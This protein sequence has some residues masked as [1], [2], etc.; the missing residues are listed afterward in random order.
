[1]DLVFLAEGYTAEQ[2]KKF[3]SDAERMT[4]FLFTASP[5]REAKDRFNVRGVFRASAESGTDQP[6]QQSFKSTALNSTYNIFDLDRYMLVEDNHLI[7]RM[8]AQVPHDVIV[9]LVNI[10][11]YGGGGMPLDYCTVSADDPFSPIVF[12]HEFGHT[13]GYLADEYIGNV[14]YNDLYPP[15]VE[16]LERTLRAS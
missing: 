1:M 15:G 13:F 4:K 12:I 10:D 2:E 5:Y 8:A 14:A 7:H 11:R 3:R 9:V 16:P 6:R